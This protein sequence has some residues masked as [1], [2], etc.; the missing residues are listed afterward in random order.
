MDD[1]AIFFEPWI[2]AD[3]RR[4]QDQLNRRVLQPDTWA[5]PFHVIAESHYGE[6]HENVPGL[7]RRI[8]EDCGFHSNHG[9]CSAFFAKL[10]KIVS[11]EEHPELERAD[12][13]RKLAFS[14]F[15]QDLLSGPR[16]AP[17]REQWDRG[18]RAF[19]EQLKLSTPQV[20]LVAGQRLWRELPTDF[21]FPLEPMQS[22]RRPDVWVNEAR[23][24]IYEV[25][26]VRHM[27]IA[28][29]VIHPSAGG[30]SFDWAKAAERA[31]TAV[32]Y[33]SNLAASEAYENWAVPCLD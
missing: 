19:P 29:Y 18:R 33:H 31:R 20:L 10:L 14:N 13:W 2:G 12:H 22:L 11:A 8:V 26:G 17:N 15:I 28:V 25:G 16:I 30:G 32:E 3:Y 6:A 4:L 7:T 9:K 1:N 23:A 24:Y 27:T 21:S 5:Y